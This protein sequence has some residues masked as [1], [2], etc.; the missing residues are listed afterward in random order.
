MG[1]D[2]YLMPE[3]TYGLGPN[4]PHRYS[5][6]VLDCCRKSILFNEI[7][8]LSSKEIV[9]PNTF[10]GDNGRYGITTFDAYGNILKSVKVKELLTLSNHEEVLDNWKNRAIWAYLACLP[11]DLDVILYWH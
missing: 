6:T 3:E 9:I 1:V 5:Q 7:A 4:Y 10:C 8:K 11:E 2:L